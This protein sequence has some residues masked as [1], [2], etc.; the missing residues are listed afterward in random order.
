MSDS[1]RPHRQQPTRLSHPGDSPCKNTGM[2]CHCLLLSCWITSNFF[3][4]Q[5]TVVRQAPLSMEFHRQ[6]YWSEL[7]FLAPGDLP[8]PR[9]EPVSPEL[10]SRFYHW[11]TRDAQTERVKPF[12]ITG[13]EAAS[14]RKMEKALLRGWY[15]Q[16]DLEKY[17]EQAM[18][19]IR[20]KIIS[21]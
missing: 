13:W 21:L 17:K 8:H 6:E 14:G 18:Q 7:P 10:A 3:E 5:Q 15:W 12:Q 11:V 4:T 19:R 2:G 20:K 16:W 1:V 9:I